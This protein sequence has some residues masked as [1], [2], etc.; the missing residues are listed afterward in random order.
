MKPGLNNIGLNDGMGWGAPLPFS[1][2]PYLLH[3]ILNI[4]YY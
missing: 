4:S 3:S 2:A 1:M